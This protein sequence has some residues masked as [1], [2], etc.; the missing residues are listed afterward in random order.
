MPALLS[1]F[2]AQR[3]NVPA[4]ARKDAV[5]RQQTTADGLYIPVATRAGD[6]PAGQNAFER[7]RYLARQEMWEEL[8]AEMGEADAARE[9]AADGT[10]IAELM[11]FGARA[12][13]V[14]AVE[15]ALSEN[16]PAHH[17]AFIEGINELES[18]LREYRGDPMI[19]AV[20]GLAHIDIAWAWR[21]TGLEDK[22]PP[23]HRERCAAHFDR[24]GDILPSCRNALPESP[25]VTS[26]NLGLLAGKRAPDIRVADEYEHLISLDPG[27]H[28]H[29]RA[30]GNHLLP[31]WFG[32]Y[33]EL[34][35]EARRTASLTHETWGMGGYT[36]V[37]FDAIALDEEACARVDVDFFLDG[38]R[39]II[40]RRPDQMMVNLLAAYC[41]ITLEK[42]F[43]LNS[44]ADIARDRICEA[45]NWLIRDHL[46]ELHPLI[47]AHAAEGFNN[48]ARITSPERLAA[49]GRSAAM[50]AIATLFLD[51]LQNGQQVVFTASG[52]QITVN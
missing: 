23:A 9:A 41:L 27:N 12:D 45:G 19:G 48:S 46:T 34:E 50:D 52:P 35:L 47:W 39:D 22:I 10:P 36:W 8:S 15:H 33:D 42:G 13:V 44:D 24:A 51:E 29:M 20:V 16:L 40:R 28:R 2:V 11:A 49:R 38:L 6:D 18:V 17:P 25:L 7:G 3:A 21:G 14:L 37:Q 5:N 31:R 43:G 1:G 32:S 30:M 26:S 4:V